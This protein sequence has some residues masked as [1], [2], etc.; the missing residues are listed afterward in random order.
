MH[1]S[2]PWLVADALDDSPVEDGRMASSGKQKTTMAKLRREAKLREQRQAKETRKD[3]RK[4]GLLEPRDPDELR[5]ARPDVI[6]GAPEAEL[7]VPEVTT[8]ELQTT[9]AEPGAKL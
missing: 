1:N 3:L 6:T 5:M 4:R 9:G 2:S 7:D 8:S